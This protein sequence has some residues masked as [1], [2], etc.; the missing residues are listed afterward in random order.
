MSYFELFTIIFLSAILL[1]V[2]V[3]R[4]YLE[5]NIVFWTLATIYL[6]AF[7]LLLGQLFFGGIEVQELGY[8]FSESYYSFHEKSILFLF[9]LWSLFK[10]ILVVSLYGIIG[11]FLVKNSSQSTAD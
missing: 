8:Y 4:R 5:N 3:L 2:W 9:M 11:F 1:L 7:F 10:I 6:L